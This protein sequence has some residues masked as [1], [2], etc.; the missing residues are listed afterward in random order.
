MYPERVFLTLGTGEALND[1]T[2]TG[3]WPKFSVRVEMVEECIQ[4]MRSLWTNDEPL[5]FDGKHFKVKDARLYTRPKTPV[6][7]Y[8]ASNG[9]TMARVAG[10]MADGYLTLPLGHDYIQNTLLPAL[11][12]G[13]KEAGRNSDEVEKIIEVELSFNP[14]YERALASC[15]RW[16]G[17]LT[18]GSVNK[19]DP[20]QIEADGRRLISKERLAQSFLIATSPDEII[21]GVERYLKMGFEH[22]QFLSMSPDETL[23]IETMADRVLPY[24]RSNWA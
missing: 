8:V 23:F 1:K 9:P 21:G 7:I 5:D 3:A 18:E 24:L 10:K 22:V 14:D 6:P 15:W 17:C 16:A 11:S 2:A 4:I 13:A 12:R 19:T 20:K